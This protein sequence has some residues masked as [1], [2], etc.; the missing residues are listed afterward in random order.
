[1]IG[2]EAEGMDLSRGFLAALIQ[3]GQE[4]LAI[5]I[6]LENAFL[7]VATVH[8]ACPAVALREGGW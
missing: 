7:V 1:M 3:C 6:L 8:D 5:V 2:H 4:L